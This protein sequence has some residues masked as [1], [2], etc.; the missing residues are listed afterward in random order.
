MGNNYLNHI[1]WLVCPDI[2]SSLYPWCKTKSGSTGVSWKVPEK[3][4]EKV[5]GIFGPGQVQQV[6]Q[7][8]QCLASHHASAKFVKIKRCCGWGYHRSLFFTLKNQ[9][10][11]ERRTISQHWTGV[12]PV[13]LGGCVRVCQLELRFWVLVSFVQGHLIYGMAR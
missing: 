10:G 5:V 4:L 3:V 6:Q 2:F 8:F 11:V 9:W 7:R 12:F 13:G 1:K